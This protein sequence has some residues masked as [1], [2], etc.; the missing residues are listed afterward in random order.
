MTIIYN[1]PKCHESAIATNFRLNNRLDSISLLMGNQS[2]TFYVM[3]IYQPGKR[4]VHCTLS[5]LPTGFLAP[6]FF[7]MKIYCVITHQLCF[8]KVY[9]GRLLRTGQRCHHTATLC[10]HAASTSVI[11]SPQDE[12]VW[13]FST[14]YRQETMT[15]NMKIS[16]GTTPHQSTAARKT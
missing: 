6:I 15:L 7:Y 10:N 12:Q 4:R 16:T 9:G 8:S 3:K 13:S 5:C 1:G 14:T 11:L 2:S